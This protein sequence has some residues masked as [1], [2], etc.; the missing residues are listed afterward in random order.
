MKVRPSHPGA[1]VQGAVLV[2]GRINFSCS[3]EAACPEVQATFAPG[4][5][6][7]SSSQ[8]GFLRHS[9]AGN[10]AEKVFCCSQQ[11]AFFA[12]PYNLPF[13]AGTQTQDLS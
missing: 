9:N 10:V 12:F 11:L 3:W 1:A 2:R 4:P 5:H 8:S 13:H 6:P 7:S